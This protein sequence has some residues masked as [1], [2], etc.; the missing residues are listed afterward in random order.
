MK[1]LAIIPARG[2]S[3]GLLNKNILSVNNHPLIAYS[4][5]AGLQT[6]S[7]CRVICS[8]DSEK[9]AKIASSYGAEVPFLRPSELAQDTS[10]DIETFIHALTWLKDKEQYSPDLV[11]QLRP[12]SP[13]RYI[14]DI[15]KGIH[16]MLENPGADSLRGI[17]VP[18]TTPY[19]MWTISKNG[20]MEPLLKLADLAEPYNQPRQILPEVWAQ[21]G[22]LEVIRTKTITKT[23]SMT[24]N[25]ILPLVI[26]EECYVDIDSSK[27]LALAEII[28]RETNCVKP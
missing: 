21:T 7:I 6:P 12:T 25:I 5:A 26:D 4:I 1:V 24:G 11:I 13:I 15:E 22:T 3:K 28:I 14:K 17:S 23:N 10:N 9:I 16:L 8:T 2:G 27:S 20:F 19:K 18:G